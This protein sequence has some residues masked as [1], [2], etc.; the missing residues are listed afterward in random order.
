MEK[1]NILILTLSFATLV[2]AGSIFYFQKGAVTAPFVVEQKPP[3]ETSQSQPQQDT[4]LKSIKD[5]SKADKDCAPENKTCK[6]RLQKIKKFIDAPL[7]DTTDWTVYKN[8]EAKFRIKYPKDWVKEIKI[9]NSNNIE[10]TIDFYTQGQYNFR[11]NPP[12][13]ATDGGDYALHFILSKDKTFQILGKFDKEAPVFLGPYKFNF[14]NGRQGVIIH[15]EG[16][17]EILAVFIPIHGSTYWFSFNP[18]NSIT[19]T[20]INSLEFEN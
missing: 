13:G 2:I 18:E 3:V 19:K 15:D 14:P 7:V 20:I 12:E 4:E 17:F 5:I 6:A 1:K 11:L 10:F 9:D 8:E 16:M